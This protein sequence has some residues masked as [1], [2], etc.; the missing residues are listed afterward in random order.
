MVSIHKRISPVKI[1]LNPCKIY[2]RVFLW[3]YRRG[4]SNWFFLLEILGPHFQV[5]SN[6]NKH[7]TFN[8]VSSRQVLKSYLCEFASFSPTYFE[9]IRGNVCVIKYNL[10]LAYMPTSHYRVI[11][12]SQQPNLLHC[13]SA[14]TK[15][16]FDKVKAFG[17][18]KKNL[19]LSTSI[20]SL[21]H[22]IEKVTLEETPRKSYVGY[23]LFSPVTLSH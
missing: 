5:W 22:W 18:K 14:C 9:V 16:F 20:H 8:W 1:S 15:H 2:V 3:L 11:K 12:V 17:A 21:K 6:F 7:V 13:S 4:G 23:E 10:A 19:I